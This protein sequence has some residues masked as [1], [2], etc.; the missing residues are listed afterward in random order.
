LAGAREAQ[1]KD[2]PAITIPIVPRK[3]QELAAGIAHKHF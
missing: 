3:G 1:A 2:V